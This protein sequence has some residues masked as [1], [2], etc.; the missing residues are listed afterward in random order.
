MSDVQPFYTPHRHTA[1]VPKQDIPQ[2]E[3][4]GFREQLG[5]KIGRTK[6]L[7]Y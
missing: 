6:L 7:E 4:Q 2:G 1:G 5:P 3:F